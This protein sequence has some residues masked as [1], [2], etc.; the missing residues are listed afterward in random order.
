M[1]QAA[2][3]ILQ[4]CL[5]LKSE[6]N[7]RNGRGQLVEN[8]RGLI[9]GIAQILTGYDNSEI[10]RVCKLCDEAKRQVFLLRPVIAMS[11]F[12]PMISTTNDCI[13]EVTHNATKR[14]DELSHPT[15][16]LQ[17]K[18]QISVIS[19]VS[20]LFLMSSKLRLQNPSDEAIRD[21]QWSCMDRLCVA[22]DEIALILRVQEFVEP[23]I[24]VVPKNDL[25][26]S[27]LDQLDINRSISSEFIDLAIRMLP[28]NLAKECRESKNVDF[29]DTLDRKL[30]KIS[31]TI[32]NISENDSSRH[33]IL[34]AAAEVQSLDSI[35]K[36]AV[37]FSATTTENAE[38][39]SYNSEVI[40]MWTQSFNKLQHVIITESNLFSAEEMA[41]QTCCHFYDYLI[42]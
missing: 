25:D 38:L 6:P 28:R 19:Q 14:I 16:Q 7:S 13:I 36:S 42:W 23:I 17:L 20:V 8:A 1:T 10:R 35:M 9:Y 4:T 37:L 33:E 3:S 22:F 2:A 40:S 11:E 34:A 29:F 18:S 24:A 5:L 26:D 30:H 41:R 21:G 31:S 12:L 39:D 15:L 32:A 27:L